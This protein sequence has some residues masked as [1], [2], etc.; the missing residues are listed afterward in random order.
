M[1][2]RAEEANV[3]QRHRARP[4]QARH[5][6]LWSPS[7]LSD[8][9]A[10]LLDPAVCLEPVGL[11]MTLPRDPMAASRL[12][13]PAERVWRHLQVDHRLQT[14]GGQF[15]RLRKH[16]YDIWTP[17]G[18]MV[19]REQP[20]AQRSQWTVEMSVNFRKGPR[21]PPSSI[22]SSSSASWT[23]PGAQVGAEL[24]LPDWGTRGRRSAASRLYGS[25]TSRSVPTP[26]F[27]SCHTKM[28][29][30]CASVSRTH[31]KT[32]FCTQPGST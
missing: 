8:I 23:P 19:Q 10:P 1:V 28:L 2:S 18:V 26:Q 11:Q 21:P 15:L 14:D 6:H 29:I 24:P 7:P 20:G 31:P 17:P 9:P 27:N 25:W 4:L 30:I 22:P 16:V 3:Q 32:T 5:W 13:S 12:W